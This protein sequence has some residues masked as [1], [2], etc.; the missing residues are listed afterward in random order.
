[1]RGMLSEEG[2]LTIGATTPGHFLD[3]ATVTE[4]EVQGMDGVR[5]PGVVEEERIRRTRW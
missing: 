2:W 1:M 3:V 4:G 5:M